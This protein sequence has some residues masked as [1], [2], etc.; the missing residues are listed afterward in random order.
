MTAADSR[1]ASSATEEHFGSFICADRVLGRNLIHSSR[2]TGLT[3]QLAGTDQSHHAASLSVV[4]AIDEE[5]AVQVVGLVLER[6]RE[7]RCAGHDDLLLLQIDPGCRDRRRSM[8][9]RGG[10]MLMP[11]ARTARCQRSASPTG[12]A[13]ACAS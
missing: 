1:S 2:A 4:E 7:L 10:R 3:R 12:P 6:P 13:P 5:F 8:P 9:Q 11:R